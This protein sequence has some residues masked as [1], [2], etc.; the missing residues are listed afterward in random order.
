M[1]L[2]GWEL[3]ESCM[4]VS[5]SSVLQMVRVVQVAGSVVD[6]KHCEHAVCDLAA[7]VFGLFR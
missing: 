3:N 7:R 5:D 4:W 1:K 2:V 6:K